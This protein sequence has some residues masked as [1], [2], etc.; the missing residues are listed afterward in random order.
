MLRSPHIAVELRHVQTEEKSALQETENG[1]TDGAVWAQ[2][3]DPD[4]RERQ[5]EQHDLG[6]V[7]I[8]S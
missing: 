6:T 7:D 8:G 4:G 3:V 5:D 1:A 2:R